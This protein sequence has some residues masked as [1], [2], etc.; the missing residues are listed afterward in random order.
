MEAFFTGEP[1][2]GADGAFGETAAGFG[3]VA[4]VDPVGGGLENNLVQADYVAF[5]E[6]GDLEILFVTAGFADDLLDRDR[7]A[8]GGVFFMDMVTLEDLTAVIVAQGGGG[9][10]GY[11]EEQIHAYGKVCGVDESCFVLLDQGPNMVDFFVPTGGADDH[12]L[13]GIHAGFNVG[14]NGVG[15]REVD[16]GVDG[17]Q[18]FLGQG[19]A[20]W[21][22]L[23]GDD[24]DVMLS[25]CCDFRYQ[26]ACLASA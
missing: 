12:I 7:S 23:R 11:V 1:F 4:E 14:Q 16:Y 10:A 21:I 24:S 5:A 3:V 9:G 20:G 6:R 13:A 22:F 25:L 18:G 15:S 19:C 8:G 26:G 17:L 2:G